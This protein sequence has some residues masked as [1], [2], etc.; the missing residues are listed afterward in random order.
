VSKGIALSKS[1]MARESTMEESALGAKINVNHG[2]IVM[3]K[4]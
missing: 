4:K 1:A 2:M 3:A